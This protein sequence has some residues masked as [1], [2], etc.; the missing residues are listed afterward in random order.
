MNKQKKSKGIF[1]KINLI[2]CVCLVLIVVMAVGVY[3]RFFSRTEKT[4]VSENE[5]YYSLNIKGVRP[6]FIEDIK[7]SVG[8]PFTLD[9]KI[10]DDMGV[11]VS[12]VESATMTEIT[13]ADG[14]IIIAPYPERSSLVLTFRIKGSINDTGFYTKDLKAINVGSWYAVRSKWCVVFGYINNVWQ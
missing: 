6:E 10:T 1:G 13:K 14:E 11:L 3:I 9:E 2:D 7:A 12:V 4:V 5:Y 8:L